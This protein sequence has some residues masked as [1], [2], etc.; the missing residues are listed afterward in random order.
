[1][2]GPEALYELL[3]TALPKV[4]GMRAGY[5]DAVVI[6]SAVDL[7]APSGGP[8]GIHREPRGRVRKAVALARGL[9]HTL[10]KDDKV[11]HEVPQANFPP[12]EARWYALSRID[13]ATVTTADGRGVAYRKRDRAQAKDLFAA[14]VE[15]HRELYRR[16]P[17]MRRRY[18]EAH[19]ELVSK[20]A[21]GRV[22]ESCTGRR[23][24]RRAEGGDPRPLG[25]GPAPRHDPAKAPAGPRLARH[26][27]V[28]LA[29]RGA[30][31][32]VDG[33]RGGRD[34]RRPAPP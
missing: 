17:E 10:S 15:A 29:R 7:P 9:A 12:I 8:P 31:S 22:F 20:E 3:P 24:R 32:G 13:G 6:P 34:G 28:V 26:R 16:F 21:W 4:R 27:G 1:L 25:R 2:R 14:S 23:G 19:T 33:P 5:P 30:R 18:R 11:H